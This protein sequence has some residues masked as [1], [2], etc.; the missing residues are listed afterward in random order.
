LDS[1]AVWRWRDTVHGAVTSLRG[2]KLSEDVAVPVER[3]AEAL[4]RLAEIGERR[5]VPTCAWGH[6]GDGNIHA[7]FLIEP[8]GAAHPEDVFDMALG[9]GGTVTGEHGLGSLKRGR[10]SPAAAALHG[11]IKQ[12]FDPKGLFN[13]GKKRA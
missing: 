1:K 2:G 9:L 7:T 12:A 8:G 10:W 13:P 11:R 4:E 3:L 6:A 5:G